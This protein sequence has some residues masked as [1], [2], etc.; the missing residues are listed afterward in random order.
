MTATV[1]NFTSF[2]WEIDHLD[3]FGATQQSGGR[4]GGNYL[5]C[6]SSG[7]S[8]G[9]SLKP[10]YPWT[11]GGVEYSGI[12][13]K[14][15]SLPA[16]DRSFYCGRFGT[17]M[18]Q[19]NIS[20]VGVVTIKQVNQGTL[21][22]STLVTCPTVVGAG[23]WYYLE[24]KCTG[25]SASGAFECRINGNSQGT[26]TTNLGTFTDWRV[27]QYLVGSS[28]FTCSFDDWIHSTGDWAP[29]GTAY[30]LAP[31]GAGAEKTSGCT[32]VYTDVDEIPAST[33]DYVQIDPTR[34]DLGADDY[35][36]FTLTDFSGSGTPM[37]V[38][39]LS[40]FTGSGGSGSTFTYAP[41]LRVSGT[42]YAH[43]DTV[44]DGL[45]EAYAWTSSSTYQKYHVWPTNPSGS[46]AWTAAA[47]NAI[48]L[49]LK[50][51]QTPASSAHWRFA[52]LQL[53]VWSYIDPNWPQPVGPAAVSL[54]HLTASASGTQKQ[55]GSGAQSLPHLQ[56][57]ASG[58]AKN[59]AT[60]TVAF[61]SLNAS[62][63]AHVSGPFAVTDLP[64]MTAS[65]AGKVIFSG[66]IAASLPAMQAAGTA[67]DVQAVGG[68][69]ATLPPLAASG[70]GYK[71]VMRRGVLLD[72]ASARPRSIHGGAIW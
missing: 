17:N 39:A 22:N 8:V 72:G 64:S 62:V 43:G 57:S 36:S 37:A 15:D 10:R 40:W 6:N 32:G 46:V 18:V 54:P 67:K 14:F 50:A 28:V 5:Y 19:A 59:Q 68:G 55:S 25:N 9:A 52:S 41:Y 60:V 30:L 27:G 20:N 49:G 69:V 45:N 12:W 4:L 65:G 53:E 13:F 2:D 44:P 33:T 61:P 71:G 7:A 1:V 35:I 58:F 3:A 29:S 48:E 11:S 38:R 51:I 66:A 63:A 26:A 24:F 47:I 56:A 70:I 31:N 16:S 42:D 34:D 21:A 23:S